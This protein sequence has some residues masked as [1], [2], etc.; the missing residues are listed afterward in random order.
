MTTV[1]SFST[2]IASLANEEISGEDCLRV[3]VGDGGDDGDWVEVAKTSAHFLDR[4][5]Q[6]LE[7][8][9]ETLPFGDKHVRID[10][11]C[12]A[13]KF[14]EAAVLLTTLEKLAV[15]DVSTSKCCAKLCN[16]F[17]SFIEVHAAATRIVAQLPTKEATHARLQ[18]SRM[19][20]QF[21]RPEPTHSSPRWAHGSHFFWARH[22]EGRTNNPSAVHPDHVFNFKLKLRFDM[23]GSRQILQQSFSTGGAAIRR[24]L[25]SQPRRGCGQQDGR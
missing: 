13:S 17:A 1:A 16:I 9:D 7:P 15:S 11:V 6:L 5:A 18:A 3:A 8:G 23:S 25:G 4:I 14:Y 22:W 12:C 21:P 20:A 10:M 19:Q 24:G 2:F